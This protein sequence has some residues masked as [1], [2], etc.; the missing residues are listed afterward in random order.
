M[1]TV[2]ILKQDGMFDLKLI[3]SFFRAAKNGQYSV[4]MDRVRK[5]NTD[6]QKGYL[7]GCVYPLILDA[8]LDAGWDD[9][10]DVNQVHSLCLDKFARTR[11]V[12]YHTGEVVEFPES[13]ATMNTIQMSTYTDKVREWARDYLN[14]EI[15]DPDPNWAKERRWK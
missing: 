15:P 7:W 8:L 11:A 1:M 2:Q 3:Y 9:I 6:K 12:N 13:T 14:I 4:T 10:Y 5:R